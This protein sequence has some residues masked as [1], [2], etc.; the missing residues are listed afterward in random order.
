M[1]G[2]EIHRTH[3]Q[4]NMIKHFQVQI[5]PESSKSRRNL[6]PDATKLATRL[7]DRLKITRMRPKKNHERGSRSPRPPDERRTQH[8]L[9]VERFSNR[10]PEAKDHSERAAN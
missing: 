9:P 7:R 4:I 3:R 1:T 6:Q 8:G 10:C 2:F 5:A